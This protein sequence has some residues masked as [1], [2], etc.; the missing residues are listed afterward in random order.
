MATDAT[1]LPV[2][3]RIRRD[4]PDQRSRRNVE[5]LQIVSGEIADAVRGGPQAG[6]LR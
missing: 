1:R 4:G 6:R 3:R 2:I 5:M